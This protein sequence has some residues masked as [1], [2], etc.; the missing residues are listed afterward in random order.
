MFFIYQVSTLVYW[1]VISLK[2]DEIGGQLYQDFTIYFNNDNLISFPR[3]YHVIH[4]QKLYVLFETPSRNKT[5]DFMIKVG[6]SDN[7]S[8]HNIESVEQ[9]DIIFSQ[10]VPSH[11]ILRAP[12]KNITE[13]IGNLPA[14]YS[15]PDI[16]KTLLLAKYQREIPP[17]VTIAPPTSDQADLSFYLIYQNWIAIYLKKNVK[18]VLNDDYIVFDN[19]FNAVPTYNI[20]QNRKLY[21]LLGN[22]TSIEYFMVFIRS[23][24]VDKLLVYDDIF[25]QEKPVYLDFQDIVNLQKYSSHYEHLGIHE[26]LSSV[27]ELSD[28]IIETFLWKYNSTGLMTNG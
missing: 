11:F 16:V 20:L 17:I 5:V 3:V 28:D 9:N 24:L 2:K 18:P 12:T 14:N 15:L 7:I 27:G 6:S 1:A 23:N 10:T 22:L 19:E 21:I 26:T 25:V 8:I 4:E 13:V